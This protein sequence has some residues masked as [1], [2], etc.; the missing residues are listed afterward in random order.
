MFGMFK[1]E[2]REEKTLTCLDCG[3][4]MQDL[5][6]GRG[7]NTNFMCHTRVKGRNCNAHCYNGKWYTG[8][9]WDAWI[10]E[11]EYEKEEQGE[12]KES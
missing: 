4:K 6:H 7:N 10:N 9:E 1:K 5:C 8:A 3:G 12:Q 11:E 2:T